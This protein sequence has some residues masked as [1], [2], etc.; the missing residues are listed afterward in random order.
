MMSRDPNIKKTSRELFYPVILGGTSCTYKWHESANPAVVNVS[1]PFPLLELTPELLYNIM[2]QG[3][4]Y[5][6]DG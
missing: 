2:T 4:P 5:G 6:R 1:K 3:S